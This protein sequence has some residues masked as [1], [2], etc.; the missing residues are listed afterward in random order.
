[1]NKIKLQNSQLDESELDSE[2]VA[3]YVTCLFDI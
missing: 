3:G 1:M 2:G